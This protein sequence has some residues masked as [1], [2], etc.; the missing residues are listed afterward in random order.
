MI[1]FLLHPVEYLRYWYAWLRWQL[2][3]PYRY[4]DPSLGDGWIRDQN[5]NLLREKWI[6]DKPKREDFGLRKKARR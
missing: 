6:A 1:D 4:G 5:R 3:G 2:K